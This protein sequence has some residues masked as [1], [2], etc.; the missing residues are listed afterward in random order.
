[1]RI[2]SNNSVWVHVPPMDSGVAT[3]ES[4]T[5]CRSA[6]QLLTSDG[7]SLMPAFFSAA[8]LAHTTLERWMSTGTE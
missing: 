6:S 1:M 4:L 7:V 8:V 2:D 5:F 3:P